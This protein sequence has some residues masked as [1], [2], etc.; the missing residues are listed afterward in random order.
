MDHELATSKFTNECTAAY[1]ATI[2]G[3]IANGI[4][5]HLARIRKAHGMFEALH[6]NDEWDA[7]TDLSLGATCML[8]RSF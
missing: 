2:H 7:D 4:V 6:R 3:F 1:I 5:N 8:S